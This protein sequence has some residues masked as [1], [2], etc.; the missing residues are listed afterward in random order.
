MHTI[1][2]LCWTIVNYCICNSHSCIQSYW[3]AVLIQITVTCTQSADITLCICT[4]EG[5]TDRYKISCIPSSLSLLSLLQLDLFLRFKKSNKFSLKIL[6]CKHKNSFWQFVC[7]YFYRK[8]NAKIKYTLIL[9]DTVKNWKR[10]I[11]LFHIK[12]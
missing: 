8:Y 6:F 1:G 7:L 10:N 11:L 5:A 9:F 12:E 3:L 2:L 4:Q